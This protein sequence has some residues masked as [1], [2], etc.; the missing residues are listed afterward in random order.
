MSRYNVKETERKWQAA[1]AEARCFE[2]AEEPERAKYY[3]LE[4]FP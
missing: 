2:V 1:W 4:M 3:V